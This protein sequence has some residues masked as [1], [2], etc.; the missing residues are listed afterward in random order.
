MKT[1]T[2]SKNIEAKMEEWI[3]TLPA[4]LHGGVR[5][6]VI[7]TGGCIASMLLGTPVKDYDLYFKDRSFL[8]RLARHYVK[9]TGEPSSHVKVFTQDQE[10]FEDRVTIYIKSSGIWKREAKS[11]PNL[12]EPIFMTENAITLANNVQIIT[13]FSGRPSEIHAN[14]DFVHATNYW[15]YKDKLVLNKEALTS[16]ITK[17]LKYA[18]SRYPLCSIIRTRKF[19]KAG[20]TINAGQYLKMAMQLN[21]LELKNP[22]VLK[23]QLVGVDS[24]YFNAFLSCL[25][26]KIDKEGLGAITTTYI[27][28][29]VDLIFDRDTA[30][31]EYDPEG[32]GGNGDD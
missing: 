29:L 19:V 24:A 9:K 22:K 25:N 32:E 30:D 20:F 10:E 11:D 23:E 28:N 16:L 21:E 8:R 27:F 13:R 6:N 5:S 4:G 18:G 15:T 1:K 17:E 26:H 31:E 7:V 3:V 2:I 12:Y 14:Y